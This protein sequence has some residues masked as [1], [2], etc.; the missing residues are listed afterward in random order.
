MLTG[1][2]W[3][4]CPAGLPFQAGVMCGTGGKQGG[5]FTQVLHI[6]GEAGGDPSYPLPHRTAPHHLQV[7]MPI[8]AGGGGCILRETLDVCLPP[9]AALSTRVPPAALA[10]LLHRCVE[11]RADAHTHPHTCKRP[12]AA[13]QV[14]G[15]AR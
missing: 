2:A 1:R 15:G 10:M 4:S 14:R 8:A 5:R 12:H 6:R 13:P 7:L 11:V 9:L 3:A